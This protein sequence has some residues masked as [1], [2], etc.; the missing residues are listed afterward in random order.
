[1][2]RPGLILL[3]VPMLA[4]GSCG[5]SSSSSEWKD[6]RAVRVTVSR[7]GLPPPGGL[8]RTTSVT[9]HSG[10]TQVTAALNKNHIRKAGSASSNNGCAGGEVILISVTRGDGSVTNLSAYRCAGKTTGDVDGD[11]PGFLSAAKI[12]GAS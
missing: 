10:L 4:L 8:P 6:V 1:M 5:G 11:V 9:S 7:P 2:H 12:P 3:V